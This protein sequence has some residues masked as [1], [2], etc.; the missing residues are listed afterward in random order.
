M[1][2]DRLIG[3]I[4][5]FLAVSP[6][7][8]AC[9]PGFEAFKKTVYAKVRR[10]CALCHDGSKATAPPFATDNADSSYNQLLSYMNFSKIEESLLVFRAGN[11]HCQKVNCQQESGKEMA[12]LADEWFQSGEKTCERNGRLFSDEVDLPA[13]LPKADQGFKTVTIDLSSIKA[14]LKGYTFQVDVQNYMDQSAVTRGAYRFRS[15]RI[16]GGN[17]AIYVKNMKVLLNG[18]YDVIYNQ[19]STVDRTFPFLAAAQENSTPVMSAATI[20]M[21][22]DG[23]EKP[24]IS[25]SFMDIELR[26]EDMQCRNQAMFISKVQP[27]LKS[28]NCASCHNSAAKSVGEGTFDCTATAQKLCGMATSLI[29]PKYTMVSPLIAVPSQGLYQHPQLTEAQRYQ[30][31]EAIRSW[32]NQ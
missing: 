19:Y 28:N 12:K 5:G 6:T 17:K 32:L 27:L 20:I 2:K 29:D 24:K 11:N 15:P 1:L 13:E 22:K 23:L 7:A 26:N 14:D 25:V 16:I 30:Y 21:M 18:K 10:D 8:L 4:F 9:D 31:V 3:V